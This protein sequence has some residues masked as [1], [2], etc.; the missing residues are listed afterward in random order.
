MWFARSKRVFVHVTIFLIFFF[1]FLFFINSKKKKSILQLFILSLFWHLSLWRNPTVYLFLVLH[2][3]LQQWW[4]RSSGSCGG[5]LPLC[6]PTIEYRSLGTAA[7]YRTTVFILF[8][9]FY[10]VFLGNAA[11]KQSSILQLNSSVRCRQ[12]CSCLIQKSTKII[13]GE[14]KIHFAFFV[15]W[16]Q[17]NLWFWWG[18]DCDVTAPPR[19]MWECLVFIGKKKKKSKAFYEWQQCPASDATWSMRK[20]ATGAA[21]E[22][23]ATIAVVVPTIIVISSFPA[24]R[25]VWGCKRLLWVAGP[26]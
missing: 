21:P 8:F 19:P 3:E 25:K 18:G 16:I 4:L 1:L 7:I 13:H 24:V 14:N 12:R 23:I 9:V 26:M 11:C 15:Q 6:T 22:L 17:G 20:E 10:F 5:L 2:M